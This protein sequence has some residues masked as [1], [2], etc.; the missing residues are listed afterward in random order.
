MNRFGE[1]NIRY[2]GTSCQDVLDVCCPEHQ[3]TYP[4]PT[5]IKP[6]VQQN[7]ITKKCGIR[8]VSGIDFTVTGNTVSI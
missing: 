4:L 1:I 2:D 8:K 6:T 3:I 5:P 7:E